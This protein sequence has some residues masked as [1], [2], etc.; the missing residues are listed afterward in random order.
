M[1]DI[2][3]KSAYP[4]ELASERKRR[5]K[6]EQNILFDIHYAS[7]TVFPLV[8][9]GYAIIHGLR[10]HKTRTLNILFDIFFS[11]RFILPSYTFAHPRIK[12]PIQKDRY[13]K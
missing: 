4:T 9:A 2:K 13:T 3:I 11:H 12:F 6:N 1:L 7:S 10:G 8:Q 5:K